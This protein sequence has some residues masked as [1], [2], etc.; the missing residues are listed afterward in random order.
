MKKRHV[1]KALA[2][3]LAIAMMLAIIPFTGIEVKAADG[4]ADTW[5]GT[6]DT[7]WLSQLASS[8]SYTL[9]SA[10]EFMGFMS[11]TNKNSISQDLHWAEISLGVDVV[12]NE[13][14]LEKLA[15]DEE[16]NV[17]ASTEGITVWQPIKNMFRGTFDGQ[18]HTISGLYS[19]GGSVGLFSNNIKGTISNVTVKDSYFYTEDGFAGGIAASSEGSIQNCSFYGVINASKVNAAMYSMGGICGLSYKESNS[20]I[21]IENCKNYGNV[22]GNNYVG[23]ICGILKAR[24]SN[25][26]NIGRVESRGDAGGICGIVDSASYFQNCV[27]YGAIEGERMG[28]IAAESNTNIE[29]CYNMGKL[30]GV[31][32]STSRAAGICYALAADINHCYNA[33]EIS[34]VQNAYGMAG[35]GKETQRNV[36]S[37]YMLSGAAASMA[38]N[39]ITTTNCDEFDLSGNFKDGLSLHSK[40]GA[41]PGNPYPIFEETI[42]SLTGISVSNSS[43]GKKAIFSAEVL[44]TDAAATYQWYISDSNST[45]GGKVIPGATDKYCSVSNDYIGKYV[46]VVAK[47]M[48]KNN[49]TVESKVEKIS[50]IILNS[51]TMN[52]DTF[53][54]NREIKTNITPNNAVV[55]YQWYRNDSKSTNG[56]VL[57]SGATS[58]SYTPTVDDL[59]HYLYV[60]ATGTDLTDGTVAAVTSSKISL[61]PIT[62]VELTNVGD[63]SSKVIT[64]IVEPNDAH[65]DYQW[66]VNDTDVTTGG[67]PINGATSSSYSA[68]KEQNGRYVYVTVK[69]KDGYEGTIST[70]F[71]DPINITDHAYGDNGFCTK[72]NSGEPAVLNGDIYEIRNAGQLCWFSA[73]VNSGE[74]SMKGSLINDIEMTDVAYT[75]M[76]TSENPYSGTF[77]GRGYKIKNLTINNETKKFTGLFGCV[78]GGTTIKNLGIEGGTITGGDFTGALVGGSSGTT[79]GTVT[80]EKCFNSATVNGSV[81]TAGIFGCSENSK[82]TIVINDCYNT[83][84]I[85]GTKESA[86]I[87]GWLGTNA[88]VTNTY[89]IG[90]I[91]G[92]DSNK[93]FARYSGSSPLKNCYQLDTLNSADDTGIT[94]K[95]LAQFSS[96]EITYLLNGSKSE[97]DLVWYQTLGTDTTPV[98]TGKTVYYNAGTNRYSNNPEFITVNIT[99]GALEYT[100]TDGSEG[101][102]NPKTH[103]FENATEA[104]WAP[105]AEG[106]DKIIVT[107][108][109]NVAVKVDFDYTN[110][111]GVTVKGTFTDGTS[112]ITEPVP[113]NPGDTTPQ[114]VVAYLKLQ[115][116]PDENIDKTNLGTVTITIG[117]NE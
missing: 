38:G 27:N 5:D 104:G 113:V 98:F 4:T 89:N 81:N 9:K 100:Y 62:N 112:P 36:S 102:W 82:A 2:S 23:G 47:G 78:N 49:G 103:S 70:A 35:Y 74:S 79:S 75:P 7:S 40:F 48:G 15:V 50:P 105:N 3:F 85:K 59:E 110:A 88:T 77:D 65:V 25:C 8:R 1:K 72:C 19:S 24:I 66:Y 57:I 101:T 111:G 83:G 68:N 87:S 17:N 60:V 73:K 28:G 16:G 91:T 33:G 71:K 10:E 55:T 114:R 12:I 69:G 93:K 96:G 34:N 109:S 22:Y 56:G 11:L 51:V 37:A 18:G 21:M 20:S 46:Y 43:S 44:P 41:N 99:W 13:N 63:C 117:G 54:Y 61:I 95:A 106:G 45:T 90:E 6:Y 53:Y 76:G 64:A 86:A 94:S 67:T 32:A 84:A 42:E 26:T 30:T 29:T 14:L 52:G 115:G 92:A 31:N 108:E 39:R 107:S 58:S 80:I 116:K 97:G